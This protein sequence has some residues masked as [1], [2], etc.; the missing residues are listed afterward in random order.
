[1]EHEAKDSFLLSNRCPRIPSLYREH[2]LKKHVKNIMHHF[3]LE[4]QY[5]IRKMTVI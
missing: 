4:I 2:H 5:L 3:L 1:M